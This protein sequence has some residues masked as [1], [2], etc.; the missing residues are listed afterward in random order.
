MYHQIAAGYQIWKIESDLRIIFFIREHIRTICN[1]LVASATDVM[2]PQTF[3]RKIKLLE[4]SVKGLRMPGVI[5][6]L[7]RMLSVCHLYCPYSTRRSPCGI[8]DILDSFPPIM[9]RKISM[10]IPGGCSEAVRMPPKVNG[11]CWKTNGPTGMVCEEGHGYIIS[12]QI[13]TAIY[14]YIHGQ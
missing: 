12:L 4:F 6:I 2:C 11:H 1:I 5:N 8:R 3:Y 7:I 14:G 13:C 10:D 9:A